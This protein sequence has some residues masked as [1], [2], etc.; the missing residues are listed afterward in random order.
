MWL[1]ISLTVGIQLCENNENQ[2][3][4]VVS[5]GIDQRSDNLAPLRRKAQSGMVQRSP[6][7]VTLSTFGGRVS[8]YLSLKLLFQWKKV[9]HYFLKKYFQENYCH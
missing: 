9:V 6:R 8:T 5:G 1:Q 3:F 4:V 2:Q 7:R